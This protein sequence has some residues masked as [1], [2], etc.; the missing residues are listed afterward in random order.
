MLVTPTKPH[1]H[2]YFLASMNYT[3]LYNLL[4]CPAGVV[5]V[6][7]VSEEDIKNVEYYE[8][9]YNDPWDAH[10]KKVCGFCTIF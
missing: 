3:I 4:N 2:L 7:K 9:H 8:S 10:I 5:P 1:I 6:T